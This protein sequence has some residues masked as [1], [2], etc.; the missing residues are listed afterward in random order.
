MGTD[1]S[2]Q[3]PLQL[4]SGGA[5]QGLVGALQALFQVN[6]GR[7]IA[8]TFGAVGLMQDKLLSGTPCDVII[9]SEALITQLIA[10]GHVAAG[11]ARPLGRVQT[12]IAVKAGAP[13]PDVRSAETLKAALQ[14]ADSIYFPDPIKATAGIHFYNKVLRA[15]GLEQALAPRLRPFP[16]GNAAMR[17]L[18]ASPDAHTLGCT[19]VTE[20]LYT[21]GVQLVAPLPAGYELATMYTAAVCSRALQPGAAAA[22][23]SLLSGPGAAEQRSACGFD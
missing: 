22:L 23:V 17:E 16:N 6:S 14:A 2:A 21:P 7:A 10:D 3:P 8:G 5:A 15:L 12:G 4:L 19:Q 18:A 1:T 11:S 9:L 20:I 13:R